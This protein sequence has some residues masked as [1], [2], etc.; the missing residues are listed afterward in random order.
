MNESDKTK[1]AGPPAPPRCKH[2][3]LPMYG[4]HERQAERH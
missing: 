3:R 4:C 1:P 2:G